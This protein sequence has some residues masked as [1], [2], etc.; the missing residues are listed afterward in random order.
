[1]GASLYNEKAELICRFIGIAG[2]WESQCADF[3]E[4]A[5]FIRTNKHEAPNHEMKADEK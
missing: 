5:I 2:A 3:D 1:L 4:K